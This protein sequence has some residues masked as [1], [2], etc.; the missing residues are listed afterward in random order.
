VKIL[1]KIAKI[2]KKII[3]PVMGFETC[4]RKHNLPLS[5]SP[6]TLQKNSEL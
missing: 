3:A 5:A 2:K 6:E 1:I 4:A